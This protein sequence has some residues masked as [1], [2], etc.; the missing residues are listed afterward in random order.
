MSLVQGIV[1]FQL[2]WWTFLFCVLPWGN[3]PSENPVPGETGNIP[4]RPRLITKF[5]IT[6]G[7][8]VVIW[9]IIY[10]LIRANVLD[11]YAMAHN[12]VLEDGLK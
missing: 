5:L 7:L 2:V 3:T 1:V 6:T 8:S 9:L 10:G 4:A 11:F 12:M